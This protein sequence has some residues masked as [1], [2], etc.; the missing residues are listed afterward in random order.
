IR[1]PFVAAESSVIELLL[2]TK[3]EASLILD[4]RPTADLE[5]GDV[6]RVERGDH[7]FRLVSMGSTNFYEAFRSKFNFRIRPD[8]MPTRREKVALSD[9]RSRSS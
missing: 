7:V 1:T 3:H 6:I 8:A 9:S 4:G 5:F 2:A